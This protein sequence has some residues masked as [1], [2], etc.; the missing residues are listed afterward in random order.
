MKARDLEDVLSDLLIVQLG[1]GADQIT[2]EARLTCDLGADSLDMVEILMAIEEVLG[3]I[4]PD[5]D[6]DSVGAAWRGADFTF[7]QL[8]ALVTKHQ[9]AA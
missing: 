5:E 6:M 4:I 9:E 3:I 7:E 1:I 2:P 8:V